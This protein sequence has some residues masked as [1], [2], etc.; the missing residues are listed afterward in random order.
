MRE[1]LQKA[2]ATFLVDYKGLNVEDMNRLRTELRN[3]GTEIQVVKN[4]LLILASQETD[5]ASLKDHFTGPCAIAITY[6]DMV[7][8]AK[9]LTNLSKEM[10]RLEIKQGQMSG[11][12]VDAD[13]IRRLAQ[14]PGREQLLGQLLSAM[15][16]V[17]GSF[18]RVLNGV[19]V[20]FLHVLKALETQKNEQ[21]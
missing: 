14:L 20:Q 1:R 18:V 12:M 11:R 16:G 2:T 21:A 4:R 5:T 8:P 19:L 9:V 15:Q 17:P 13:A 7:G 3:V 6:D 10:D